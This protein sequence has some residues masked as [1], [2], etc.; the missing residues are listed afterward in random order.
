MEEGVMR[1]FLVGLLIVCVPLLAYGGDEVGHWYLDPNVGGITPDAE[2]GLKE[3]ANLD[4]GLA[5]GKNLSEDWSFEL[6]LNGARPDYKHISGTLGMYD[7]SLD[8]LRVWNRGGTFAPY[9]SV[10]LGS[11]TLVP[12]GSTPNHTFMATQAGIGAFIKLWEN[13]DASRS[14][15]LRPDAEF[16]GDRFTQSDSKSDYLY[17]LGLVFTFGPGTPPPVAAPPPPPTPPSPPP[18][19]PTPPVQKSVCPT[20]EVPA[21]G[22]AVDANGCPLKGDV[23]LE[24]VNFQTNSAEL[25]GDSTPILDNVAKG[26]REHPRLTVEV[27]GHTDS[28]GSAIYNLALSE[29]RAESVRA[30][31]VSQGVSASQLS[32]KGYGLTR[33]IASNKT[34]AGRAANRRVVIHVIDNPG[35]VT[36][37]EEGEPQE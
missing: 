35:N 28:T 22:A 9:L 8:V 27:Q 29:R 7:A 26:L 5:I 25:T 36:I 1:H 18:P 16:R 10:G 6:N 2:W 11:I 15:S 34:A 30:Y 20:G 24:G 23:V 33:P 32:A 31:L 21:P 4:Y 14:L 12:S 19:P 17:T 37:H 13:A 3:G